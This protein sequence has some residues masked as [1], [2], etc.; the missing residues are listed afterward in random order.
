V[1]KEIDKADVIRKVAECKKE[2]DA[3]EKQR[4]AL[5]VDQEEFVFKIADVIEDFKNFPR[6]YEK[7]SRENKMKLLREC[8]QEIKK[9]GDNYTILFKDAFKILFKPELFKLQEVLVY[10][11]MLPR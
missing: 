5:S 2:I 7:S 4:Q 11:V 9:D 8:V 10:H 1:E 3:M 6:I